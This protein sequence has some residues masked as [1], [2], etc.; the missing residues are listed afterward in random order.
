MTKD[1]ISANLIR[2]IKHVYDKATNAVLFNGNVRDWFRTTVGVRQG[3]LLSPTLFNI[4]L[5]RIMTDALQDHEGTVGIG[6]RTITNLRFADDIDGLAGE[7]EGVATL[8]RHLD[9]ASTDYGMEV[10]AEKK[11]LMTNKTCGINKKI[12]KSQRTEA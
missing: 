6:G 10:S 3:C 12:K 5:E 8:V 11:K 1:D 9:K 4:F 7:E 2:V